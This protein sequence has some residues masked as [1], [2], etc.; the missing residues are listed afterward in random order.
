MII[1]I[2]TPLYNRASFLVNLHKSIT[3]QNDS[4]LEWIIVDDGSTDHAEEEVIKLK[5]QSPFKII[6]HYQTN[7]GKHFAINKGLDLASGTLFLILDSDDFLSVNAIK[8][9]R[10]YYNSIKDNP[11]IAGIAG[12][13]NFKDGTLVGNQPFKE[14]ISNSI[15]IRYQ[16]HTKGDLVEIFKTEIFKKF[17]FPEIENEKFCPEVL[18]W[19]R[20]AQHY[21]LLFFNIGIYTT[22]YLKGGLTDKIV[23]IR[24][25]SPI[26]SMLTYSELASYNIPFLQRLKAY[27]NFWRFA[28]NS[29]LSFYK[30]V[31]M[32]KH[33]TALFLWPFGLILYLKDKLNWL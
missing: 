9:I 11:K 32:L 2:F 24:M 8:H 6:Y 30:K 25:M 21:Q 15:E 3:K 14:V 7:K 33:K 18:V 26:A 29:Q 1:S 16:Y 17:K 12:K 19:N 20:I 23:K 31:N 4:Q 10:H 13:R 28:F 5:K 22:Q 27:T